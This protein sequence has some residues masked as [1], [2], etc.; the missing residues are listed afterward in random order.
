MELQKF[1][2]SMTRRHDSAARAPLRRV[3]RIT[4]KLSLNSWAEDQHLLQR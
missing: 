3:Q 2:G 4:Y 1:G